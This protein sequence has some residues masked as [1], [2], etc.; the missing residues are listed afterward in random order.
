[1]I[2]LYLVT[3]SVSMHA[4]FISISLQS[5][6][7]L[8]R[9]RVPKMED[10]EGFDM[11][12]LN[13]SKIMGVMGVMGVMGLRGNYYELSHEPWT[14]W[15]L[16]A[17]RASR[18]LFALCSLRSEKTQLI[19]TSGLYIWCKLMQID[20]TCSDD[21]KRLWFLNADQCRSSTASFGTFVW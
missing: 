9:W 4:R 15:G 18:R 11:K 1:M 2:L 5:E 21:S 16:W 12:V 17:P 6:L 3:L 13:K 7:D 10:A 14:L 20:S 8:H 19:R